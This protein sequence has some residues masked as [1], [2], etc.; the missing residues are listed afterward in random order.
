MSWLSVGCAAVAAALF[1]AAPAPLPS[2]RRRGSPWWVV[3]PPMVFAGFVSL[4]GHT[5]LVALLLAAAGWATAALARRSRAR[6]TADATRVQVIEACEAIASE[7]RSGQPPL[8][9]LAH[10]LD[11]WPTLEPVVAACRLDAD[12]PQAFRRISATPGAESLAEVASAWE[13]AHRAGAGL[14]HALD[15]V[16]DNARG[17]LAT[18]RVV[19]S[20]LASAQATARMIALMP[21]VMIVLSDGSGAAPWHF[22]LET[23]P[24][25]TCLGAGIGLAL[26]GMWWIDRIVAR[27]HAGEV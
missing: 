9:A 11:T 8:T 22:L 3:L 16:V 12:V 5:L 24:G 2:S 27:V 17:Q 10:S 20:E 7:L 25:L 19:A 21:V 13:L 4:H 26:A 15:R 14:A 23:S 1:M 6:A 18:H